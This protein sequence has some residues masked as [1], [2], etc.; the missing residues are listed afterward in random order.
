MAALT[1]DEIIT[2]ARNHCTSELTLTIKDVKDC[3]IYAYGVDTS[4]AWCVYV[5]NQNSYM[6]LL[7]KQKFI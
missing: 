7:S 3:R 4:N 5:D 1:E 2:I 6:G